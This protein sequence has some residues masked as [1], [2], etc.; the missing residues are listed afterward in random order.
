M[1][2]KLEYVRVRLTFEL[3]CNRKYTGG[4]KNDYHNNI[5]FHETY[6]KDVLCSLCFLE[7]P[8]KEAL[9]PSRGLLHL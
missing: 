9:S 6:F 3:G 5:E 8:Q 1:F 7:G 2:E 4:F